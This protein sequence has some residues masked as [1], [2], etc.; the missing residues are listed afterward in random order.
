MESERKQDQGERERGDE[1]VTCQQDLGHIRFP[2]YDPVSPKH[3]L[4]DNLSMSHKGQAEL[5]V[6]D[7]ADILRDDV[8]QIRI[9]H[10]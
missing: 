1:S 7:A 9:P 2:K 8:Q 10:V 6:L 5:V 4:K 3:L